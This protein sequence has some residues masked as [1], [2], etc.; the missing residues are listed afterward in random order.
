MTTSLWN[1]EFDMKK[2]T[3]NRSQL[4]VGTFGLKYT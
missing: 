3:P 1:A 2:M 4:S